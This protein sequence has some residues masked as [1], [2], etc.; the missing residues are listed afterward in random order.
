MDQQTSEPPTGDEGTHATDWPPG[1]GEM[2]RLVRST[3]WSKTQLG[4]IED[5]P[6]SLKTMLGVV[7]G[8]RF[9]MMIWWGPE[10]FNFYNDAYRPILR[11]KHPAS[12]GA[13]AAKLW[14]EI[15]DFAGPLARGILDGGP[16][17][18][19]E[20]VQLFIASGAMAEETYFTFSYSPVPGDDGRV[21]G[22]LNTVQETTAKVQSER[23]IRMLHDLAARASD[24]KSESDAY[25]IVLDVL[26]TNEMDLPFTLLYLLKNTADAAQLFGTSGCSSSEVAARFAQVPLAHGMD[27]CTWPIGEVAKSG[28]EI[29]I[30][31][32]AVRFGPMPN[33]RW[34]AR[35]ERAIALPLCRVGQQAP[36][37]VLVAGI[38]P[39]RALDERYQRFFRATADQIMAVIANARAHEEERERAR[40]LAEIDQAKTEFF[41]NVSHE[42]R[43]PLTLMLG[44]LEDEL[45]E[46]GQPLPPERHQ[47]LETVHRN[48]LRLLKLVNTLLDFSR[49]E[50]GRMQTHYQPTDLAELTTELASSFESVIERAGLALTID[51]PPL[52]EAVHVDREMWEKIVLNL[53]SNAFKHTFEGGIIVR[54]A[55][56]DGAAQLCVEDTGIGIPPDEL[57]RLFERFHR[58]KGAASRTHEGTGIGL[59]LVRELVQLHAGTIRAESELGKGS[60]FVVTLR[61]DRANLPADQLG[62]SEGDHARGRAATAYV[63]EALSSLSTGSGTITAQT[64]PESTV[65]RARVLV[66]DDNPDMRRYIARLLARDYDVLPVTD[67]EAALEVAIS[68]QP[69]LVLSDVMMPRLDGFG[70]LK[71]LRADQRTR[72]VPVILVSARAGDEATVE[73]M[74]AGADD[75]L[76]KPFSARELLARVRA[77]LELARQRRELEQELERRVA[78]RTAEV[79]RLTRVLQMLSGITTAVVRIRDRME[80][81]REAC[82]IA[83]RVGQYSS[84]VISFVEPGTRHARPSAWAGLDDASMQSLVFSV[85]HTANGDSSIT[86]RVLRSG[87]V[88]LCNDVEQLDPSIASWETLRDAEFRSV[89]ALPLTVDGTAVGVF[90]LT[91][92]DSQAV[93]DE[94]LGLLQEVAANLS[95]ALGHFETQSAV[96]FLSYFDPLT[97]LANR[98]L[99]CERL[100]RRKPEPKAPGSQ[101]SIA[102]LDI[103]HLGIINDSYGRHTGDHLLQQ[104]AFRLKLLVGVHELLGYLGGGSFALALE[105]VADQEEALCQLQRHMRGLFERSYQIEGRDIPVTAKSGLAYPDE[106]GIDAELLVQNAEAALWQAKATG[107][108]YHHH[109]HDLSSR[110][111]AR[112]ALEHR[113]RGALAGDQYT[114]FYQPKIDIASGRIDGAEALLRWADPERGLIA[115]GEFLPILEST[116]MILD[117]GEWIMS[118]ALTDC[119]RWKGLRLRPIHVAVNCSPLQLRQQGFVNQVANLL[120]D[121][122]FDGWGI[123]LEITE[124]MLIDPSSPEVHNLRALRD[125]GMRVA[126]DDFGT[127]YS[128]LSRLSELPVDILKIDRSFIAGLPHDRAATRLVPTIIALARAFELLTVAEGVETQD[129]FAF[130]KQA[131]CDQ[132]QGF[133]HARPMPASEFEKL[134]TQPALAADSEGP[135]D[136][137]TGRSLARNR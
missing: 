120:A 59:S 137:G 23:Q 20:D 66:A 89:V 40:A 76:V 117:V 67:G 4:P 58:V 47:R 105:Q 18:W 124:S 74:D 122:T 54:L 115:P 73:G 43:T 95:F 46:R 94:E 60:R 72:H 90:K 13:P 49:I 109:R 79:V 52:P 35:P 133:L 8:S 135:S 53:V 34:N 32:L 123:D 99:F 104:V 103:E 96:E 63:Q 61:V 10:L 91:A 69:D 102:V 98:A 80:L 48:G 57:P 114:L 37:A 75:Y 106:E 121:Y 28:H 27:E 128:S 50:A 92:Q 45:G 127:G 97:G 113:L 118:R 2:G 100:A 3:D 42:F 6:R 71:A 11:D 136:A 14:A 62:G 70:L 77:H 16:A 87:E 125:A 39:H 134:L 30:D 130:L 112:L 126:I 31:D 17:T 81:F 15:W 26:S 132:S 1:G 19:M 110:L 84:A 44:P 116:G 68:A 64:L 93:G 51:C 65:H 21:G 107:E 24:A 5:W 9:P 12:L 111:S 33:G 131:G 86:G 85:A 101:T 82:R 25:R 119:R 78:T 29:L 36:Y 108:Q 83:T 38:S 41:S 55:W 56:V 7:L 88:F 22:L 129:Q